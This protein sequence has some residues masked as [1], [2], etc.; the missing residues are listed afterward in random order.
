MCRSRGDKYLLLSPKGQ[1]IKDGP[2]QGAWRLLMRLKNVSCSLSF[3]RGRQSLPIQKPSRPCLSSV[4]SLQAGG[5]FRELK[6][7]AHLPFPILPLFDTCL[8]LFV[9]TEGV[10]V[11]MERAPL[12]QEEISGKRDNPGFL[13][14]RSFEEAGGS[15]AQ[16]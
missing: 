11:G 16:Q 2:K 6:R 10:V 9:S 12:F 14:S 8:P 3:S 13:S 7:C 15:Q 4:F 5:Y 1:W